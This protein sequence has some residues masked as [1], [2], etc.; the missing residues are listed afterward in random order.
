[1]NLNEE[2]K[3]INEFFNNVTVDE[4]DQIL[5]RCGI[6]EIQ[7]SNSEGKEIAVNYH[8]EDEYYNSKGKISLE[9]DYVNNTFEEKIQNDLTRAA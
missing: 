3:K 8:N 4:F 9:K 6:N 2:I 5:E 1:M 7:S